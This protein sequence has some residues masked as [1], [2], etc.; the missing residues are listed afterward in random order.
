MS[1]HKS[2]RSADA[3][4]RQRNVFT[5]YERLLILQKDKRWKDGDAIFGLPKVRTSFRVKSKAKGKPEDD[6]EGEDKKD[7]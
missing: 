7:E 6:D 4:K 2:L 1:L 5:R 3:L